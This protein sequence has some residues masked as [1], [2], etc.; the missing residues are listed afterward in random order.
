MKTQPET[1]SPL[2]QNEIINFFTNHS[3]A[4]LSIN[5][6][7]TILEYLRYELN[8]GVIP[9]FLDD[10][11]GD[12]NDLF[13]LID[14]ASEEEWVK[15]SKENKPLFEKGESGEGNNTDEK[16]IIN[17]T[18]NNEDYVNSEAGKSVRAFFNLYKLEDAQENLWSIVKTALTN[19]A[20]N[21]SAA[22]RTNTLTFYDN[23]K[24]LIKAIYV[25]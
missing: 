10:F 21:A 17:P 20:D 14:T 9:L 23:L 12:L 24:E 3:P 11:L 22:D 2:F 16:A 1:I 6:R 25:L 19:E 18:E 4:R 5:L 7:R 13:E 8:G 15:N